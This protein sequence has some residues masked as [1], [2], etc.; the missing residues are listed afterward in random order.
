MQYAIM[1]LER[2]ADFESRNDPSRMGAYWGAY[3]AYAAA[4][5]EAG[6]A[7]GGQALQPPH[8]GTTVRV[9]DGK[10][11]VQDGPFA[12]T[13]EKLGGVFVIDVPDLDTALTWAARCPAAGWGAVEVRPILSMP[14]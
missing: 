3:A 2:D 14:G 13:K 12:D 10:R 7:A 4:L 9:R 6:V 8:T 5:K 1:V 11:T